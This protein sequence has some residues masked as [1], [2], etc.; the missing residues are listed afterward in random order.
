MGIISAQAQ[1]PTFKKGDKVINA[2]IGLGS[3]LYSGIGYSTQIPPISASLEIGVKDDF[4]TDKL[5][6]GL[7]GYLGFSKYKWDYSST[8]YG[9]NWGYTYSNLIIGGRVAAHYPFLDKL[10]TYG[11]IMIGF[12]IVTD[13]EYGTNSGFTANSH[14][15]GLVWSSFLGARY[16]FNDKIAAMGEIGYGIA[17]LNLGLS[18]KF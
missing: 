18:Y 9:Y 13:K 5:S 17:W 7:G 6:V 12:D 11:G 1:E 3:V 4:L 10:D 2:S 16:Y 14:G 15:S 8:Y